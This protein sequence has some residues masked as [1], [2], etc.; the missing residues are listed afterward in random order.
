MFKALTQHCCMGM[1]WPT[2]EFHS[3][4]DRPEKVLSKEL[5]VLTD[6]RVT[7]KNR[8]EVQMEELSVLEHSAT[9]GTCWVKKKKPDRI[10][11]I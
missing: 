11:P 1:R 10:N 9:E 6:E 8:E 4:I 7:W 3:A 5:T 2:C